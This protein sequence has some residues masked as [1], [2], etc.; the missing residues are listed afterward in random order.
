[1]R[2]TLRIISL[3][4]LIFGAAFVVFAIMAMDSTLNPPFPMPVMHVIYKVY[5]IVTV[6]LF[7]LSFIVKEKGNDRDHLQKGE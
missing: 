5:P 3:V 7:L 2:R 4:M 1:M 6:G